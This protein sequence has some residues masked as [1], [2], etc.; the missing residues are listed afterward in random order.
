MDRTVNS[1]RICS[2]PTPWVLRDRPWVWGERTYLMGVLN[3]TPDSFSD[4]GQFDHLEAAIAQA[5]RLVAD[6]A[7]WLDIGGESTRPDAQPVSAQEELE[8]VVPVIEA[9]QRGWRE[10]GPL[11]V[12]ISIDTTKATVARSAIEAGADVVNDV[13]GGLYD[14]DLL[15]T[16]AA[17]GVPVMLMHL[18]G[19]PQ[20]MQQ[21][22]DYS[23]YGDVVAA[24][25]AGL[26]ERVAAAIAAG[27]PAGLIAIDP[28]I[29]FAK[30]AAQNLELLRRLPELRSLGYPLLVG[31][32]R[33]RFIGKILDEPDPTQRVW[34]TGAACAACVAG[35]ADW[36]RVHD[37]RPMRDVVRVADAIWRGWPDRE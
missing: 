35:G 14:P 30:T 17:L 25:A 23:D 6:G 22:T 21:L 1:L 5:H 31:P 7:D 2:P 26:Q 36:V 24:V 10:F 28:G 19:T 20:T 29:G 32:S 27:V 11:D 34:G 4:G 16:V 3:V 15:P 37:V 18:R 33:K 9:L 12:P 8:R 13:S